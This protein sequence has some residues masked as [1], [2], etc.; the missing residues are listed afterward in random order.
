LV[1]PFASVAADPVVEHQVVAAG[2]GH[3]ERVELEA[4]QP[5]DHAQHRY[6]P[7]RERPRRIEEMAADQESAGVVG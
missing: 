4:P 5:I 6:R 2:S 7:R 3:L 1:A